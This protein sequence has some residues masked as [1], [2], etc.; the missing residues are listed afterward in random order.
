MN[1]D[2]AAVGQLLRMEEL[3]L[4]MA[5]A[6]ASKNAIAIMT[7]D[8]AVRLAIRYSSL[9]EGGRVRLVPPTTVVN[10]PSLRHESR[11]RLYARWTFLGPQRAPPAGFAR[12]A[13]AWGLAPERNYPLLCISMRHHNI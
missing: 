11:R 3:I 6:L 9:L 1:L 10:G 7:M 4:T 5:R 13:G 12:Q 2:E 8:G